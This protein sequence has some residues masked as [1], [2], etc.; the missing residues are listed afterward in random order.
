[1]SSGLNLPPGKRSRGF[2]GNGK[3]FRFEKEIWKDPVIDR[4]VASAFSAEVFF[5]QKRRIF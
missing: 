2:A 5:L 4:G 1:M 3:A